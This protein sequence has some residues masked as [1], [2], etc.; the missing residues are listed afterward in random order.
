M[1]TL[2]FFVVVVC[3]D[4]VAWMMHADDDAGDGVVENLLLLAVIRK[5]ALLEAQ[6]NHPRCSWSDH[7]RTAQL[8][9]KIK[10]QGPTVAGS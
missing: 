3:D 5:V 1:L 4:V 2:L 7:R 8:R 9:M 10:C 6:E